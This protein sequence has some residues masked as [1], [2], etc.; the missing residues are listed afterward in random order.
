MAG[1]HKLTL[2]CD[3]R[4]R[5]RTL[6]GLIENLI[7]PQPEALTLFEHAGAWR[8][9]AYYAEP[10]APAAL[11]KRIGALTEDPIPDPTASVVPDVNWVALSQAALP[12]VTVG[13][14]TTHGSHDRHRV[15]FGPNTIEIEA[16]EAF[17]T[18]HHATTQGCLDAIDRLARFIRVHRMLDLGCGSGV[19]AIAAARVWPGAR[20][21]ATDLDAAAVTVSAANVRLNRV[22]SRVA[23]S[24]RDGVGPLAR[25]KSYDLVVAN[26]LAAPLITLAPRLAKTVPQGRWLVLSGILIDQAREVIAAYRAAGFRLHAHRRVTG[27]SVLYL[28]NA[29]PSMTRRVPPQSKPATSSKPARR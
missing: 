26:I 21:D 13:R 12:P 5:A 8:I 2:D 23:V 3:D 27:W 18:A 24:G 1:E 9:E 19:L 20:I 29:R 6:A 16:G 17:G 14:F 4:D 28:L 22:G 25:Q 11:A 10:L 15:A 7:E